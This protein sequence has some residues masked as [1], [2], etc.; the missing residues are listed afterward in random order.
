MIEVKANILHRSVFIPEEKVVCEIKFTNKSRKDHASAIQQLAHQRHSSDTRIIA[1]GSW[2]KGI[3]MNAKVSNDQ[4]LSVAYASAQIY[5]QCSLNQRKY[6]IP[7]NFTTT[8]LDQSSKHTSFSSDQGIVS[9][10]E[11]IYTDVCVY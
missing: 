5:C 8:K 2:N 7:P 10:S 6:R 11:C 9:L 3:S 1:P 4:S